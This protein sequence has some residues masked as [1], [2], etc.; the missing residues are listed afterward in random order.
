MPIFDLLARATPKDFAALGY[1]LI[2]SLGSLSVSASDLMGAWLYEWLERSFTGM[3]LLNAGT[4]ALVLVAIPVLP[5]ALVAH[6][7]GDAL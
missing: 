1:A 3:I 6:R 7:D 2:F 4:S 5:R